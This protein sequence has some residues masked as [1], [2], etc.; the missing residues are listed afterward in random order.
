LTP[1]RPLIQRLPFG[2]GPE[3]HPWIEANP[4]MPI[5]SICHKEIKRPGPDGV[6][7]T[8]GEWVHWGHCMGVWDDRNDQPPDNSPEAVARARAALDRARAAGRLRHWEPSTLRERQ[9]AGSQSTATGDTL[10][11]ASA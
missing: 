10:R 6:P 4:T 2:P 5:C 11:D 9:L 8:T 1:P 7:F 3:N